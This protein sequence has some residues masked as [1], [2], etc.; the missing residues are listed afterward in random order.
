MPLLDPGLNR[1][2]VL[3]I[4]FDHHPRQR[5]APFPMPPTVFVERIKDLTE[6]MVTLTQ[7]EITKVIHEYLVYQGLKHKVQ[8][9]ERFGP[10]GEY[11]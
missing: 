10:V 3:R 7:R 11:T 5:L 6:Q 8:P 2:A 9:N 4:V 1:S